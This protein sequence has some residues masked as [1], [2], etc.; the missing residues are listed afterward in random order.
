VIA[1]NDAGWVWDPS[2]YA[3]SAA[4]PRPPRGAI[5]DSVHRHLGP[6]RRAGQG[7]LPT[8]TPAGEDSVYRAAGFTISGRVE[9]PARF[10][11]RTADDVIASVFSLSSSAPHL[12]GDRRATFETEL[13]ALLNDASPTGLFSEK[14]REI[15]V[16]IWTP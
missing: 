15:A 10:V 8:G 3:G 6:A 9:F 4:H 1:H 2:L 13:R 14:M 5:T 12:F 11:T 7:T 16:D